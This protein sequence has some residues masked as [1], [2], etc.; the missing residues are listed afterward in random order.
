M[1][2]MMYIRT[3]AKT[4]SVADARTHLADILDDVEAGKEIQLTRRGRAVAVVLSPERYEAL[5]KKHTDFRDAYR[6]FVSRYSL[7]DIGL[8]ADFFESVR[9][10]ESGR[11]VRL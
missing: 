9:D 11:R 1:Y 3:V 2:I 10:R 7:E 8:E 5:Q 6:T 4:Y